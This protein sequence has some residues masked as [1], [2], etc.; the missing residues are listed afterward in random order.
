MLI[1]VFRPFNWPFGPCVLLVWLS[2]CQLSRAVSALLSL[3]LKKK[4]RPHWNLHSRQNSETY[5][6]TLE[7]TANAAEIEIE[8]FQDLM[9]LCLCFQPRPPCFN[10][11]LYP[12]SATTAASEIWIRRQERP[13]ASMGRQLRGRWMGGKRREGGSH[14]ELCL[15]FTGPKTGGKQRE[16]ERVMGGL[17]AVNGVFHKAVALSLAADHAWHII[18]GS[19]LSRGL[20]RFRFMCWQRLGLIT[21]LD[22]EVLCLAT[23]SNHIFF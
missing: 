10:V 13:A 23:F 8:D 7:A 12:L 3:F 19:G 20:G 17:S 21:N 5:A 22:F 18:W 14:S 1:T 11:G 15:T 16:R 4:S 6:S 9:N 2:P